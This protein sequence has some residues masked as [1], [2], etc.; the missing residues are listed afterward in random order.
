[1]VQLI[2]H[3]AAAKLVSAHVAAVMVLV[4]AAEV[5]ACWVV[6]PVVLQQALKGNVA[7]QEL[8]ADTATQHRCAQ[9]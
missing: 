6:L 5:A 1:M 2:L 9:P 8:A 3:V 4:I 7:R